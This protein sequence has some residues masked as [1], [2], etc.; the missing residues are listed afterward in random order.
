MYKRRIFVLPGSGVAD[1]AGLSCGTFQQFSVSTSAG[2]VGY[3][4][5]WRTGGFGAGNRNRWYPHYLA[6]VV[7][8][9]D[10][11]QTDV[12]VGSWSDLPA[13]G[14]TV[15]FSG[16]YHLSYETLMAAISYGLA[17]EGY[18]LQSAAGLLA[19][20]NAH[21]R[22]I[23]NSYETPILLCYDSTAVRL[24]QNGRNLEIIVRD[25]VL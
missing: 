19:E 13:A 3:R 11:D 25:A 21:G 14:E 18:S 16:M 22:L 20:L 24:M 4:S 2:R 7:I 15:G 1:H 17:G 10:R 12:Q 5:F 23:Q 6:T 8:A 9:I